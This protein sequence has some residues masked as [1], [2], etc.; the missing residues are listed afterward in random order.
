MQLGPV[1]QGV[2]LPPIGGGGACGLGGHFSSRCREVHVSGE[3]CYGSE[4]PPG[5]GGGK[6]QVVADALVDVWECEVAS[7][8]SFRLC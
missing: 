7:P 6:G 8:R 1:L 3:C 4:S 2:R 5:M